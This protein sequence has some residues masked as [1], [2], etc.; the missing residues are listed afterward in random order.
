MFRIQFA[1]PLTALWAVL[2]LTSALSATQPDFNGDGVADLAIGAPGEDINGLAAAGAVQVVYGRAAAGLTPANQRITMGGIQLAEGAIADHAGFRFGEVLAWGDFNGDHFSDLAVGMP[3][4][5]TLWPNGG[6]VIILNGSPAGLQ[7]TNVRHLSSSYIRGVDTNWENGD[8]LG[9]AL[10]AGDFDHNG[11]DDLAIGVPGQ[12]GI[13]NGVAVVDAGEVIVVYGFPVI[14]LDRFQATG[15]SQNGRDG[16]WPDIEGHPQT[17]DRF[18]RSLAAGDFNLDGVADLAIGIPGESNGAGAVNIVYGS[19]LRLHPFA[20][21]LNRLWHKNSPGV[22]GASAAGEN[23]GYALAVGDFDNDQRDDLAISGPGYDNG[24]GDVVILY[25]S[26]PDGI[27]PAVNALGGGAQR[28]SMSSTGVP[29]DGIFAGDHF[30]AALCTGDFN[31]DGRAD[32]A[33]GAPDD[34]PML[35]GVRLNS[36]GSVVVIY[37]DP[38]GL[39]LAV[40]IMRQMWVQTRANVAGTMEAFDWFGASLVAGDYDDNGSDDLAIG[41]PMDR[42]VGVRAG[43][44]NVIYGAPAGLN[45][46]NG[47][48]NRLITQSWLGNDPPEA[49]DDFGWLTPFIPVP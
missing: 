23:F 10:A 6:I 49:N 42:V 48:G 34:D 47:P 39:N 1:F 40:P 26:S 35:N 13:D 44:V 36:A 25:G 24:A 32:L 9:A 11:C 21:A 19:N 29:G 2:L 17:G 3:R 22:P 20:G 12:D 28:F 45:P 16:A 43:A 37:S 7:R 38:N 33:I 30:G 41:V 15:L 31:G 4:Y 18:G 8:W 27:D 5:T 14:G 46:A